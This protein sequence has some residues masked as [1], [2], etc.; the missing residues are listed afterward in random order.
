M[1]HGVSVPG[2][3]DAEHEHSHPGER[4]YIKIAVILSV[5]TLIEV[6]IY[7]LGLPNGLLVTMLLSFSALKFV[8]VVGYFMHLKFDDKRLMYIFVAGLGLALVILLILDT[9][10][11]AVTLDYAQDVFTGQ[12]APAAGEE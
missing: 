8:T 9:L 10:H 11:K 3:H 1:A 12:V 4:T 6:V 2:G 5:I 7:Y